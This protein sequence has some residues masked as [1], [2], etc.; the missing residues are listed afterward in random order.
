MAIILDNAGAQNGWNGDK[1][2][3]RIQVEYPPSGVTK[4]KIMLAE[5]KIM[6]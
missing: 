1:G 2:A 3:A 4:R 5:E 6:R